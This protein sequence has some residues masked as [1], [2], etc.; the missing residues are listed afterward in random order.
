MPILRNIVFALALLPA[1]VRAA[2]VADARQVVTIVYD[3]GQYTA[4]LDRALHEADTRG[5]F[6]GRGSTAAGRSK[7]R[8][9]TRAS[10][11][12]QRESVLRAT[13]DALAAKASDQQLRELLRVAGGGAVT[14]KGL[15]DSAV[16]ATKASFND[17]L[18]AQMTR[19][20]RGNAEFPCQRGDR[21]HCQ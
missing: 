21:S 11:L 7:D 10:M 13:V 12:A 8:D 19:V 1:T 4:E 3:M 5:V 2:N 16:A 18:W 17:A 14:D 20:A 6:G 15:V 9:L